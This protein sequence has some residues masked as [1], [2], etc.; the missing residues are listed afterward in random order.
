MTFS[1]GGPGAKFCA[2]HPE[3]RKNSRTVIRDAAFALDVQKI[4]I[5]ALQGAWRSLPG[6]HGPFIYLTTFG[7]VVVV[8]SCF[9][10]WNRTVAQRLRECSR[11]PLPIAP[12]GLEASIPVLLPESPAS[13]SGERG[14]DASFSS[15]SRLSPHA[16]R[17]PLSTSL[18]YR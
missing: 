14:Q 11:A 5:R 9:V 10:I 13:M 1:E 16:P 8:E 4:H 17:P 7:R 12:P 15:V 18:F 2:W 3:E 6:K